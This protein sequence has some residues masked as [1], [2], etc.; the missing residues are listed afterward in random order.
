[1]FLS[2][3][4]NILQL[5]CHQY[6]VFFS[7][8]LHDSVLDCLLDLDLTAVLSELENVTEFLINLT[9][10][11][12]YTFFAPS[13]EAF[14]TFSDV[15]RPSSWMILGGHIVNG[16]KPIFTNRLQQGQILTPIDDQ[17]SLHVTTVSSRRVSMREIKP[18]NYEFSTVSL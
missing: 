11:R 9:N 17:Y 18:Y 16:S 1:M 4:T 3:W 10:E 12:S 14:D 6:N 7:S 15:E 5:N 13:N 2:A 8:V